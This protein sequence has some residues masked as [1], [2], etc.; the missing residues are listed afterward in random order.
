MSQAKQT[1]DHRAIRR[2][3]EQRGGT[4][5]TVKST[6]KGESAGL[7]RIDFPEEQPD[8]ELKSIDWQT[9][10]EK[11]DREKLAFLYQEETD[12]GQTS[13]FCKFVHRAK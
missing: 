13:R 11:F 4:P 2:W 8:S 10:F 9:F 7:L 5:A 6:T 1:T 3:V 12:S